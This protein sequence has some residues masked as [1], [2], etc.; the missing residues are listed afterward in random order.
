MKVGI[1]KSIIEQ[2]DLEKLQFLLR[3][4]VNKK[5]CSLLLKDF[6]E[7]NVRQDFSGKDK[8]MLKAAFEKTIFESLKPDCLVK[9]GSEQEDTKKEFSLDE[10]VLYL[11]QP[12]G[13][14]VENNLTDPHLLRAIFRCYEGRN[15][16]LNECE[17]NSDL[18]Y[19]NAGGC[20]NMLNWVKA[21]M[22]RWNNRTKFLRLFVVI[23]SDKRFPD[24]L[25]R[26]SRLTNLLIQYGI[27]YHV[28]H[29][30][31]MENYL[32]TQA[33]NS[34]SAQMGQWKMAY[35]SLTPEQRDYYYVADGFMKDI[36]T[37]QSGKISIPE[38][39]A[40][41]SS[42]GA[43]NYHI[44]LNGCPLG[45]FKTTFPALFDDMRYVNRKSLDE[46]TSHQSQS[47]ELEQLTK[48][49]KDLI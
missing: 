41:Y 38:I 17:Q 37:K 20:A 21:E 1:D 39:A 48:R 2:G 6:D 49:L 25:F 14:L 31:C 46:V 36:D 3:Q 44:L 22:E 43:G 23:D 35:E 33:Y 40:L 28:W 30:R 29:K 4:I 8:E 15:G 12:F 42:V 34:S 24:D 45:N 32:P 19:E 7:D 27:P 26:Y 10:A 18:R 13:I 16:I 9:V 47:D 11:K 5:G